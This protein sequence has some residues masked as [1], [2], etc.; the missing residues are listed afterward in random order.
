MLAGNMK[1][2]VVTVW[3]WLMSL[4]IWADPDS[5]RSSVQQMN[6]VYEKCCLRLRSE[7]SG[8]ETP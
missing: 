8:C 1:V 3:H 5:G 7:M 2:R 4:L 6:Q